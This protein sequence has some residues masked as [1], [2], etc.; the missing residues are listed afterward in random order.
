MILPSL[1]QLGGLISLYFL[2]K[3]VYSTYCATLSACADLGVPKVYRGATETSFKWME[4]VAFGASGFEVLISISDAGSTCCF[5][6]TYAVFE[7]IYIINASRQI[8]L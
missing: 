4:L 2:A 6:F 7:K 5:L 8:N 1:I 3:M